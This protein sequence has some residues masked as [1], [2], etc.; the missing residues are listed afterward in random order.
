MTGPVVIIMEDVQNAPP[1]I[2]LCVLILCVMLQDR[3]TA[4][5]S[6]SLNAVITAEYDHAI[7]RVGFN[8]LQTMNIGTQNVAIRFRY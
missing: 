3:I 6:T 5:S 4:V 1:I 2:R 7:T 8:I